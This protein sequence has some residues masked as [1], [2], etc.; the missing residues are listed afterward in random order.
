MVMV[1]AQAQA[2][3]HAVAGPR[4]GRE[5][6]GPSPPLPVF[7]G[8]LLLR[9]AAAT[10]TV[11][12]TVVT[13]AVTVAAAVA[14]AVLHLDLR[15]RR[16]RAGLGWV[17][18]SLAGS[19]RGSGTTRSTRCAPFQGIVFALVRVSSAGYARGRGTSLCGSR[20]SSL[21]SGLAFNGAWAAGSRF[22]GS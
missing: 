20:A 5:Q 18:L 6:A 12:V 11:T 16:A 17:R 3:A 7:A 21:H 19:H 1:L 15:L 8:L 14:G 2:L 4:V 10:V 13:I 22:D 9:L